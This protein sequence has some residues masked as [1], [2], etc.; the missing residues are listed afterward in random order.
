MLQ[1][2]SWESERV[3]QTAYIRFTVSHLQA[4]DRGALDKQGL[5]HLPQSLDRRR[6]KY[7]GSNAHQ[8]IKQFALCTQLELFHAHDE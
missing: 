3:K 2:R 5:P 1:P 4:E 7:V 6:A 8:P